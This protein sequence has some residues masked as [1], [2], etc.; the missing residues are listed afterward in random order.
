MTMVSSS[1]IATYDV[2]AHVRS[3]ERPDFILYRSTSG[4]RSP[5][6]NFVHRT[7]KEKNGLSKLLTLAAFDHDLQRCIGPAVT[8]AESFGQRENHEGLHFEAA[9][10]DHGR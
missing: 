2:I 6:V 3:Q 10:V 5:D 7:A 8:Y 1:P 4:T 9:Q